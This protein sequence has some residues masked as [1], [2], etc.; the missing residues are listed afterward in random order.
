MAE[1]Q[2]SL[3]KNVTE[4]EPREAAVKEAGPTEEKQ[5]WGVNADSPPWADVPATRTTEVATP[6]EDPIFRLAEKGVSMDQLEKLIAMRDREREYQSK[7][8]FDQHFAEMQEE[9]SE[10]G[11]AP[12]PKNV[13]GKYNY[14][15]I[16]TLVKHYGPIISRHGFS[17]RFYEHT[18][19]DGRLE[20][21][22]DVSGYGHTKTNSKILPVYQPDTA[23]SGK[24]IQ[25]VLQAEGV[26]STYGQRYVFIAAFG[27]VSEQDDTDGLGFEEGVK[28]ADYINAMEACTTLADLKA[29]A[30]KYRDELMAQKDL[31]GGQVILAL[32]NRL[33]PPLEAKEKRNNA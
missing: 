12:R 16:N 30:K 15:P 29:T 6:V 25:N 5:L 9:F 20:V 14:A 1:K 7:L 4:D 3:I 19:E 31:D 13:D 2:Q 23:Q 10:A 11:P 27:L 18:L 26:R 17:Y 21:F 28:Y 8:E 22:V 24:P 32:F 33:K